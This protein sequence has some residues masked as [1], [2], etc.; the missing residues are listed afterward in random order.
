MSRAASVDLGEAT[1]VRLSARAATPSD[2][3]DD[4]ITDPSV[5]VRAA[6][7]MNDAASAEA[8]RRLAR[9][10]DE[11][12]RALLARKL[13]NLLPGLTGDAQERLQQETWDLLSLLVADEAVRVRAAIADVVKDMAE[14]PRELIAQLAR[15]AALPVREPVVRLSPLLTPDD[16]LA[17]LTE[18][19]GPQTALAIARRAWIDEAVSD[20]VAETTHDEAIRALL[21]NPSAQIREAT[22]DAL[23]ARSVE[24]VDWHEP[25]V[26]R[27]KLT[28]NAASAL[29]RIV[30][31][32]L[33]TV[34]ASRVDLPEQVADELR[35]RLAKRLGAADAAPPARPEPSFAASLAE[36]RLLA[37]RSELTEELVLGAVR[38]G[39]V[40]SSAAQ[41][42]VAAGVALSVVERATTLRS[43]K[44]L[45]S[46]VWKAG[47]SM[48]AAVALQGLLGRLPPD[49]I[50]T[51]GQ[52]GKFPLAVEEMRWQLDFLSRMGG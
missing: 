21:A 36:A 35:C 18:S 38:R 16:L 20:A 41:L 50:L 43:G 28:P 29:S 51:P 12:V 14:A 40:V 8:N 3:L 9:D 2:V 17:L 24:H 11:R 48:R 32:D 6:L 26:H 5:T 49:A 34:L 10:E 27:P 33:L 44:A 25:L 46:L 4:F 39:D 37:A 22:L 42:A 47:F 7:A 45:V 15:D 31:T 52:D 1:R 13:A 19:P 30:V 23:I